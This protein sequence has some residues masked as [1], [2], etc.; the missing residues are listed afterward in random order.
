MIAMNS[1][2]PA[3]LAAVAATLLLAA[4]SKGDEPAAAANAAPTVSV[5]TVQMRA[6]EGGLTASGVLVPREEATVAPELSGFRV[7]QVLVDQGDFVRRGQV[8][9]R[10]DDTLLQAQ[11]DQARASLAQQQVAAE[12]SAAE[13]AR[14]EGLD[15]QGV[16]SEEAIAER[17]MAAR[18]AQA[19]VAVAQAQLKDLQT[20]QSRMTITAPVEGR[21]LERTVRPGDTSQAGSAM[22]RMARG[23]II[24]LDAEVPETEL[25]RVRPG[26]RASVQLPGGTEVAGV[27][28]LVSPTVDRQTNLG[29]ARLTLPVRA[30]LRPGGF[31]KAVFAATGG[32]VA[33]VPEAAIRYDA[34]GAS[35]MVVQPDNRVRR[36]PVSTG[37]RSGGWV[38]LRQGPA[39]GSRVAL[40]GSAFV[41][42]GDLV[43]PTAPAPTTAAAR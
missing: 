10:L 37:A 29:R 25:V 21:I 33:A 39:A 12:R 7:A 4:C 27:V 23:G 36:V 28:R 34:D 31:A 6:V 38:E 1:I 41:L 11:V 24:E 9:A 14:V 40:G 43:R 16:L 13:A 26:G 15:D 17:R 20:R 8:L 2:R 18:S 32:S 42:E 35:V 22:F 30:D 19:G 3:G 5:A